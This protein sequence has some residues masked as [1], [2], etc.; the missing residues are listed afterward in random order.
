MMNKRF[1]APPPLLKSIRVAAV[2]GLL[3]SASLAFAGGPPDWLRAAASQPTTGYSNETNAVVLLDERSLTV[4]DSGE[5]I[6]LHRLAIKILRPSG[7]EDAIFP[8]FFDKETKLNFVHI[9]TITAAGKEYEVKEKELLERSA[10]EGLLYADDRYKIARLPGLD[11]G[12]VVGYEYEQKQRPYLLD[13]QWRFQRDLPVKLARYTLNLPG[14]WEYKSFWGNYPSVEPVALGNNQWRWE[15][16]DIPALEEEPSR[17]SNG[18]IGGRMLLTYFGEVHGGHGNGNRSWN[19]F[20]KW[21]Y[22]LSQGR[23]DA[24]PEI[25]QKVAQL[26][27]NAPDTLSKMR[28]ITTFLQTDIRYVAIEI[29]VGGYQPHSASEIFRN[30]YGDCKDKA[31]LLSSMLHQIG[32][33]SDYVIV[34]THRGVVLP[35]APADQFNHVILAIRLPQGLESSS[36]QS[37]AQSKLGIKYLI[38]DPTNPFV[39][40]GEIPN[41]EQGSYGL[42]AA[43]EGGELIRFPVS[44]PDSNQLRRTAHLKLAPDGTLTGEVE[45]IRTGYNAWHNRAELIGSSDVDRTKELDHFLSSF[46]DG[47]TVQSSKVENLDR[48]DQDLIIR[49]TFTAN[50]YAKKAGTLLLV[51]PRVIGSNLRGMGSKPRKYPWEFAAASRHSDVFELEVPEGYEL[52]ELPDPIK[53]DVGFADYQSKTEF[54]K[55]VIR[56]SRDYTIHD[57]EVPLGRYPDLQKLYAYINRDEHNSVV[58]KQKTN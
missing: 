40:L 4:R 1:C 13:G 44:A 11:P 50:S 52:E 53:I 39:P 24:S 54:S 48:Y 35:E 36:F 19:D 17:L 29:G 21:Y 9:W 25:Q 51:R 57:L 28:A 34:H 23:R 33:E 41:Y 26:T 2:T 12:T 18:A 6:G 47:F 31:T 46:L 27:A 58:L 22:N 38:F 55:N 30:R 8:I 20:G 43:P 42:L 5:T 14:G 7:R 3:W 45:E 32:I 15:L 37:V 10:F 49:Y 56:Y 16:K